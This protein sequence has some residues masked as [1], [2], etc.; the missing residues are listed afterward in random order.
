MKTDVILPVSVGSL[1]ECSALV[2]YLRLVG[3][4][5]ALGHC[6]LLVGAA[7]AF[8]GCSNWV[9]LKSRHWAFAFLSL[10]GP[11]GLVP[12]L[13]L[14]YRISVDELEELIIEARRGSLDGPLKA[15]SDE[16]DQ[17]R[18][19]MIIGRLEQLLGELRHRD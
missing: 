10:G 15:T 3:V 18:R 13:L 5:P 8:W 11:A 14:E 7:L 12:I 19:D 1:L 6:L 4:P 17:A 2:V 9:Q 16:E